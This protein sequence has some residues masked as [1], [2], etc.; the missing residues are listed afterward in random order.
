MHSSS[1]GIKLHSARSSIPRR[2]VTRL[3]QDSTSH[4]SRC[5][6]GFVI[7][8]LND[9]CSRCLSVIDRRCGLNLRPH[10]RGVVAMRRNKRQQVPQGLLM[11]ITRSL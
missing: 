10:Q 5:R 11:A 1:S 9:E 4:P 2:S 7:N 6:A 8:S 3:R